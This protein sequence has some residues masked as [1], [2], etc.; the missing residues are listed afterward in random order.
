MK[1]RELGPEHSKQSVAQYTSACWPTNPGQYIN[2]EPS[3][4]Q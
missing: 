4:G 3:Y 2:P 1:S